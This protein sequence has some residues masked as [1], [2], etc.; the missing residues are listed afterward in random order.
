MSL[1][2]K[3]LRDLDARHA[4]EDQRAL[5]NEVRPLPA[6]E[7]HH[8]ARPALAVLLVVLGAGAWA[9]WT[10]LGRPAPEPSAPVALAPAQVETPT[11]PMLVIA[12]P[13][14]TAE[15]AAPAPATPTAAVPS[16]VSSLHLSTTLQASAAEAPAPAH[17]EKEIHDDGH[18]RADAAYRSALA[19]Q[20]QG[21]GAS[22]LAIV[23][24]LLQQQPGDANARQLLLSLLVERH[25]WP[26]AET[27]LREGLQLMPT[28]S[29]WAMALA[30]IQ[31]E[32][33]ETGE[34]WATLEKYMAA[35]ESNADYQGFAAVL[36]QRLGRSAEAVGYYQAAL[37]LKPDA[38][39]WAGLGL[40]LDASGHRD[41]ARDA[42]R[43]AQI[44]GGLPSEMAAVVERHLQ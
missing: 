32:R 16:P 40:A 7:D 30:R 9:G 8:P 37:R 33:G 2:N 19:A 14:P 35:G 24:P 34:A 10:Y 21:D 22:A 3:V 42:F 23:R 27:A 17:V 20:R 29:G 5:P 28:N 39:W 4:A 41:E 12:A 44:I 43:Q 18:E 6:A 26:E 1:I 13:E 36:L 38:R 25:Q 31:V 15:T 11:L